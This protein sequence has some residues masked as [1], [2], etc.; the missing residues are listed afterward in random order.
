MYKHLH[1]RK[2][3]LSTTRKQNFHNDHVIIL[4]TNK[5]TAQTE[6]ELKHSSKKKKTKVTLSSQSPNQKKQT[7]HTP[8]FPNRNTNVPHLA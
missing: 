6:S 7:K 8:Y 4:L 5:H 2:P 1:N 3:S